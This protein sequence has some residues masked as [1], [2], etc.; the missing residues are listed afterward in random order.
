M[1]VGLWAVGWR[2]TAYVALLVAALLLL[3]GGAVA[4]DPDT[5]GHL[6]LAGSAA[7]CLAAW[8]AN[9]V[10]MSTVES[11]P[12]AALGLPLSARGAR[13]LA[14]GVGFGL[15][16]IA[17]TV[18]VMLVAGWASWSGG[19]GS[20]L[21]SFG[22]TLYVSLLL[23]L[24][25]LF[26]ELAVRGYPFQLLGRS[27][28]AALAIGGT[29]LAFALLHGANPGVGGTALANTFLAG[30]LLGIL[31]WKTLS[32]WLVTGVHFAWNWAMGVAAGLPVSGLDVGPRVAGLTVDGPEL[33]T[34]GGYG[35][36]GGLV[37]TLVT[38]SGIAWTAL[39]P[40]LSR[41]PEV[42]ALRPPLHEHA[43]VRMAAA[44]GFRGGP[45]PVRTESEE[46]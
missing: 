18:L 24:A 26:E 17:G 8:I 35:P 25:A 7:A 42:I 29:A 9:W 45:E 22:S 23:V 12:P 46:S 30:I 28:G 44:E 33:W 39:T 16:L 38:I 5:L 31:Y 3:L 32:L 34:G 41:D 1:L 13:D 15:T 6:T 11:R 19:P 27:G 4:L 20:V 10:M 37:L 40:R 21:P 43:G 2:L 14:R 36:E